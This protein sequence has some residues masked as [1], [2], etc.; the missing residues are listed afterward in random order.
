MASGAGEKKASAEANHA[1][2][3][4]I[5]SIRE[6]LYSFIASTSTLVSYCHHWLLLVYIINKPLHSL[7]DYYRDLYSCFS[8]LVLVL[9]LAWALDSC[10]YL[11][12]WIWLC[13]LTLP[14]R[15]YGFFCFSDLDLFSRFLVIVTMCLSG[16]FV[17]WVYRFL[18][19]S[20]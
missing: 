4:I 1:P 18:S 19:S 16:F 10:T 9:D 5:S 11:S 6:L 7:L 15:F 17:Y 8:S 14:F 20:W 3:N 2:L 12:L 13:D